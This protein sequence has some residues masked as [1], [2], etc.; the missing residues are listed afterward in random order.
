M[1]NE[2]GIG[3]HHMYLQVNV[4]E[5]ILLSYERLKLG[6][7]SDSL[8]YWSEGDTCPLFYHTDCFMRH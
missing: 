6:H 8:L 5:S 1:N 7:V 2:H 4:N 3:T